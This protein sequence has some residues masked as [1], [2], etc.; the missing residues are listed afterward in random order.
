M[1]SDTFYNNLDT[2]LDSFLQDHSSYLVGSLMLRQMRIK[3]G[4]FMI[5]SMLNLNLS[6][7]IC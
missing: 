6:L 5:R 4:N 7:L 2:Q 1:K 3:N